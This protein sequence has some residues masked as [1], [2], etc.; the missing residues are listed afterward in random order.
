ML[1]RVLITMRQPE[2]VEVAALYPFTVTV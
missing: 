2:E 1:R